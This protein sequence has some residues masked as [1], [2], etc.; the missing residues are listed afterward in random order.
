[1]LRLQIS[2]SLLA[3]LAV[4]VAAG[5]LIGHGWSALGAAVFLFLLAGI[6]AKP[7]WKRIYDPDPKGEGGILRFLSFKGRDARPGPKGRPPFRGG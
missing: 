5:F 1:V 4:V 6:D 7:S 2:S 3:F